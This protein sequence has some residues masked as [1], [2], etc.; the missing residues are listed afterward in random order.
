MGGAL[1]REGAGGLGDEL[2]SCAA[3]V[4]GGAGAGGRLAAPTCTGRTPAVS[5]KVHPNPALCCGSASLPTSP[6]MPGTR[7][8]D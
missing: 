1:F 2:R 3:A 8:S 4:C 5:V 7:L 6:G